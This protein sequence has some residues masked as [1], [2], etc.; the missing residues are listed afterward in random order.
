MTR[1]SKVL[2]FC[3]AAMLAF[4]ILSG[5]AFASPVPQSSATPASQSK[6]RHTS[7]ATS[8]PTSSQIAAARAKGMVWVNTKSRVYHTGGRYYGKTKHGQFMSLADAKRNGYKAA[9]R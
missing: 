3:L 4:P 2:S 1:C 7:S 6:P 5:A 8:E 9:R